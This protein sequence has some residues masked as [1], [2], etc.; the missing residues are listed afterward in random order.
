MI[1]QT[2]LSSQLPGTCIEVNE[3]ACP[4]NRAARGQP[5]DGVQWNRKV[6]YGSVRCRQLDQSIPIG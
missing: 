1:A 6:A 3:I 4:L 5:V 2:R